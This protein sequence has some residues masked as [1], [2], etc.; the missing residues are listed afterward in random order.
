[1]SLLRREPQP[2]A[3]HRSLRQQ[4]EFSPNPSTEPARL[5][6]PASGKI[7][8]PRALDNRCGNVLLFGF[9]KWSRFALGRVAHEGF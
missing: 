7:A 8:G 3:K 5:L 4:R 1:M 9:A 6:W 2:S